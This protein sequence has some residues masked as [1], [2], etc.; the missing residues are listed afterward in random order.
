M[1][2]LT[3]FP[4]MVVAAGPIIVLAAGIPWLIDRRRAK[5]GTKAPSLLGEWL[6][7]KKA[8]VCPLLEWV[9]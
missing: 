9:D 6:R 1:I 8:K 3:L 5:R 2:A 4:L 7:A